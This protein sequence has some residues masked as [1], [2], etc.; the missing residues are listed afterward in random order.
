M[1]TL[2]CLLGLLLIVL[3]GPLFAQTGQLGYDQG[4]VDLVNVQSSD[5]PYCEK[6]MEGMTTTITSS[7]RLDYSGT[8]LGS[9]PS[10]RSRLKYYFN[11]TSAVS[12]WDEKVL[13][14]SAV[15]TN[16]A[17]E[18]DNGGVG[19]CYGADIELEYWNGSAWT[20]LNDFPITAGWNSGSVPPRLDMNVA[21]FTS[22]VEKADERFVINWG[23]NFPELP[24]G[25]VDRRIRVMRYPIDV[26]GEEDDSAGMNFMIEVCCLY[27]AENR[28]ITA[29]YN[30]ACTGENANL[31]SADTN[32]T[33]NLYL[34]CEYE[35]ACQQ[36]IPEDLVY[37][38]QWIN[39]NIDP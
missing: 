4:V 1:K 32:T 7:I 24:T 12:S 33:L 29:C 35:D 34:I 25:A 15:F 17:S 2:R 16:S 6:N 20:Y 18:A 23:G 26:N 39:L 9:S 37:G 3:A 11:F 5:G 21:L 27:P 10:V 28:S 14:S 19:A 38:N 30:G 13:T 36:W 31:L 22:R 8:A